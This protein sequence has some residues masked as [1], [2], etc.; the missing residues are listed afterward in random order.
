MARV[1]RKNIAAFLWLCTGQLMVLFICSPLSFGKEI[2]GRVQD[3]SGAAIAHARLELRSHDRQETTYA[4]AAGNFEIKTTADRWTLV[5]AAPGFQPAILQDRAIAD[6]SIITLRVAGIAQTVTVTGEPNPTPLDQT[7]A[8]VVILTPAELTSQAAVT[9]DEALRQVPG[10][11]LFRRSSSLT[12]NPTTQGASSRGV[13]A[14]G[15][16]RMLVLADEIPLNDPFG[17]WVYWDRMPRISLD[18]AEVLRGGGS[19]LYGSGALGGTVEL[20]TEK[21]TRTAVFEA[22]GNSLAGGDFQAQLARTFGKWTIESTGEWFGNEGAFVVAAEDRGAVDTPA[23]LN[24]GNGTFHLTR[25]IGDQQRIFVGGS[26][27]TESRNNGTELQVN[28]THLGELESGAD[29]K[30]GSNDV[31]LRLYGTG[32]HYHQ[33]FS[34]IAAGR[35]SE[36]LTRWQ[37]A[38]SDQIGFSARWSRIVS[39]LHLSAGLD[40]RFI[41]GESDDTVFVN[42]LPSS[43]VSAGGRD[44]AIG[45]Y[46]EISAPISRKLRLS[47]G[48][49]VDRWS[50][51]DGFQNTTT[52]SNGALVPGP[53]ASH[54]ETAFDPRAG[55]VYDLGPQ[56]QLTASVYKG[57]RAPSLNELYRTFRLGNVVTLANNDLTAEHLTGGEAGVR[58]LRKNMMLSAAFFDEHVDQPIGNVTQS[59]TPALI[60]RKRQNIGSLNAIGSDV[61]ALI[62]FR[63]IQLRAGYEYVHSVV[64]S[65][66]AEP[67]L[68]GNF[69]PQVPAH[70]GTFSAIYLGPQH[71]TILGLVRM[72][73]QQFD[74]DLNQFPLAGYSEVGVSVSKQIKAVTYFASAAN[75]LDAKIP[76]A[77]TP[78]T[79]YALP[80]VISGG[81]RFSVGR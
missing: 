18:R 35:N 79:N 66:S 41:H 50:N 12:A 24:F 47:G 4:D 57:F 49:R 78:I 36:T 46:G 42:N 25:Q 70:I 52:L 74:D 73:S 38:P 29:M 81:V 68:V 58:F 16:S 48:L 69:V 19:A 39:V 72:A 34:S 3:Q 43:L 17:G 59:T 71:W 10:F 77:A 1:N 9:L 30:L 67:D 5:V 61:D 65:F 63:R 13:G 45:M 28:S 40:G 14:S 8:N 44:D 64:T 2:R 56:W 31:S 23:S 33:S 76:T 37:T 60:T 53:L 27:F 80:R 62:S 55:V 26:I 21:P 22:S 20:L 6:P 54:H 11:T 75:L 32:E 15:A 51:T 7:A